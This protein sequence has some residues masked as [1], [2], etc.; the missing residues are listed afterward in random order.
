MTATEASKCH[1]L[2]IGAGITGLAIARELL[3]QGAEDILVIEKEDHLGA[4]ASGR[5]SGVLHAGIYY[6]PDSLKA[7]FSVEGNRLMKAY[8]RAHG[9]TLQE[10]GKVIVTK[11]PEE[12]EGLYDLKTRADASGAQTRIIDR[13]ELREIEPHAA[14]IEAALFSPNTAVIR[15]IEILQA[16]AD[17]IE[18]SGRARV[19]LG[20]QFLGL[21]GD[22]TAR[23]SHRN[24]TFNRFI[25][26]AGVYADRIAHMFE[27]GREYEIL[28]FKGTYKRVRASR[29]DLVRGSIY[30]VPDLRNPFLGVHFTRTADDRIYIGPSAIP[31]FGR[32][33]YAILEGLGWETPLI[34]ARDAVLLF[35]NA[36]FRSAA[37]SEPIMTFKRFLYQEAKKLVPRL[38]MDD[39]ENTDK[40]GIR[41]QL[42]HWPSKQ[43]VTDFVLL[44]DD[45]SLHILNAVSPAF[46]CSLAFAR[47]VVDAHLEP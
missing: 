5:N 3:H 25:N 39:L 6:T 23:T 38:Q 26:A 46:T 44:Q 33:N 16:I 30:P 36:G 41:S 35:K 21:G 14:T 10:T 4:H 29:S 43:M 13:R 2:I 18:R 11:R 8:C 27:L 15:P 40:I 47:H 19:H 34:A 31:A 7:R 37:M 9:L 45:R 22:R 24:I 17:E 32:E 12:L 42:V 20:E 1:T 28:P